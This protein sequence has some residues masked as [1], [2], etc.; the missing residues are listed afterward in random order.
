MFTPHTV[1][2]KSFSHPPLF[3]QLFWSGCVA[4]W[5]CAVIAQHALKQTCSRATTFGKIMWEGCY[6]WQ[7]HLQNAWEGRRLSN[8]LRPLPPAP[9]DYLMWAYCILRRYVLQFSFYVTGYMAVMADWLTTGNWNLICQKHWFGMR[10]RYFLVSF[11]TLEH[12]F[13]DLGRPG[14]PQ[15]T[16]WGPDLDFQCFWDGFWRPPGHLFYDIL[17][18]RRDFGD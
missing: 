17:V 12:H 7:V 13:G 4:K 5:S 9:P 18:L 10:G 11:G 16:S 6:F 8:G 1:L 3:F 2:Q 15:R 14:G